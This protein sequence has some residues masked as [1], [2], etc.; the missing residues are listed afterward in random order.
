[1]LWRDGRA[2]GGRN[3]STTSSLC[4]LDEMKASKVDLLLVW[5]SIRH[6]TRPPISTLPRLWA[7]VAHS[8]GLRRRT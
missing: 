6:L 3:R 7:L 1:M 8:S 2:L 4:L 5:G